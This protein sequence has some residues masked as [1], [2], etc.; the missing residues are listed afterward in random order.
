MGGSSPLARGGQNLT[1]EV[2]ERG[3]LIP[4]GAGRTESPTVYRGSTRAHPRWRGEDSSSSFS[5]SSSVGSS[6]LARGG[7]H[8]SVCSRSEC[9]LIPA[10]AGRTL[11]PLLVRCWWGAHPRWRGEDPRAGRAARLFRGSSPLA[12]GGRGPVVA[13]GEQQ[14]LIPAGAGRTAWAGGPVTASRA[15]PRWR[16]EDVRQA[17]VLVQRV[18]S[19]PL[20][21]GGQVADKPV[22]D[23][24]GLIPAGAGRTRGLDALR[25]FFGAHPRWRGEDS[26][27]CSMVSDSWGSSPLA[28]GGL[29]AGLD[30]VGADGLIPAG[31]GRTARR[32]P[33][34]SPRAAHPRWRGEDL[35]CAQRVSGAYGSSPLA[36]GGLPLVS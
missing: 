27:E 16:G 14:R 28:R 30:V 32:A 34:R 3:R 7:R 23:C 20:A 2:V 17:T 12:R 26:L 11:C 21:R 9:R 19:S 15:H 25:G 1:R 4:A 35:G 5:S 10:G 8:R 29:A 36:R 24:H 6:P 33:A 22:A 31:A 18:G 13:V